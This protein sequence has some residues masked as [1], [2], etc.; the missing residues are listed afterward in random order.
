MKKTNIGIVGI[1]AIGTVISLS[2]KLSS[3]IYYFNR[4]EITALNLYRNAV[5]ESKIIE[6][7][8]NGKVQKLNWLI[9]CLKEY[10]YHEADRLLRSLI[11]SETKVLV[12]RNGLYLKERLLKYT[13]AENII[14]TIIDCSVQISKDQTYEIKRIP[15]LTLSDHDNFY[16]V[17]DLFKQDKIKLRKTSDLK[18]VGWKKLIESSSLGGI[19][20]LAGRN[21]KIFSDPEI[22][23]L[24]LKLLDEGILVAKA[25]GAIIEDSFKKT[26]LN[27]LNLYD[28]H[29]ESSM[30][31]DRRLGRPIEIMAK[32]GLI[33]QIA[34]KYGVTAPLNKSITMFLKH[35]SN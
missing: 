23:E 31:I 2:L 19:L 10:H 28:E 33:A 9:V 15:I 34:I 5:L 12:I 22:V 32:N 35:I 1:G 29:K 21:F 14:E 24:Y 6:L 30:L 13:K 18:T 26:L 11:C 17:N 4:S 3:N 27:K 20:C 7:T 25:D 8:S 16:A